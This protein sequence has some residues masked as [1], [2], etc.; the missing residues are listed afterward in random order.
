MEYINLKAQY[1]YLKSEIDTNIQNVLNKANFIL[2]DY[3]SEFEHRFAEYIGVKYAIG[4]SDGTAALQLAYMAYGVGSGDAV[5]CPDMT[6]VASIEPAVMLGA[7]PVFCDIDPRTYNIDID[8]L[9]KQILA[10]KEEGVLTP[11]VVVAVDF[12]GNP[13]NHEGIFEIAQKYDLLVI[14]DAAQGIGASINGKMCGSF[15]NIAT[16]SFFPSKPLGCYGDGGAVLTNDEDMAKLLCSLRVHGKGKDKYHNIRIGVNSRL[17]TLQA[18]I[19]LPKLSA[20]SFEME[21]RMEV[22]DYYNRLL[23]DYVVTP[24]VEEGNISSYAQYVVSTDNFEKRDIIRTK[25]DDN[26]IPSLL[27]YPMP[28]HSMPVFVNY[29]NYG[30]DF[31]NSIQY[32][33]TSFGIPFS[34]YIEKKEQ[35]KVAKT[36]ISAL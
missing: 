10:V 16:T 8:S 1:Q 22:A 36:I 32:S 6:F 11:R 27:Y 21:K 9:E 35:E 12:L 29:N 14:E 25:L 33:E 2:G 28:L 26:D 4:C 18:A 19:L 34:P 13:A 24:Y 17:D 15:G 31:K 30:M 20:L 7:T 3:V 23:R 5:F